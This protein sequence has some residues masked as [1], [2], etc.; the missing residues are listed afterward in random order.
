MIVW[1]NPRSRKSSGEITEQYA[2]L[3]N[4]PKV[5]RKAAQ[6]ACWPLNQLKNPA[7][8][9]FLARSSL[10]KLVKLRKLYGMTHKNKRRRTQKR[11]YVCVAC[12]NVAFLQRWKAEAKSG[13]RARCLACG[14]TLLKPSELPDK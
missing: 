4:D 9:D 1:G 8:L 3:I 13:F 5:S 10:L 12:K 6:P 7:I 14:G 2:R 11:K